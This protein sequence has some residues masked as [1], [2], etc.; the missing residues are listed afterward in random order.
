MVWR[1]GP[2]DGPSGIDTVRNQAT[3]R[4]GMNIALTPRHKQFV[5]QKVNSGAY[6]SA[7]E[8]VREGLRLL[9]AQD[10]RQRRIAWLQGEVDRGFEGPAT[11]W[12]ASDADRVRHMLA[13]AARRRG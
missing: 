9:E 1:D 5:A 12:T 3:M 13:K 4:V 7:T 2:T 10:E 11:R 6:G 8:V